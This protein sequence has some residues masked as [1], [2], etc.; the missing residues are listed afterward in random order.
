MIHKSTW[1]GNGFQRGKNIINPLLCEDTEENRKFLF[2][3]FKIIAKHYFDPLQESELPLLKALSESVFK[4][5]MQERILSKVIQTLKDSD[6]GGKEL[7]KRLAVYL[8]EGIY[9]RVFERDNPINLS[10]GSLVAIN[11]QILTMPLI[12]KLIILKRKNLLN[13]SNMIEM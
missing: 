9:Y 11:L 10:E 8:P 13:S 5:P 2:N 7:R 3:F 1:G 6:K 12:L 4:L